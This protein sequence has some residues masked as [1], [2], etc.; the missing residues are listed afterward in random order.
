MTLGYHEDMWVTHGVSHYKEMRMSGRREEI[1]P[2]GLGDGKKQKEKKRYEERR[3]GRGRR[4][5]KIG[6]FFL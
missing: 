2:T 5:W 1:P 6:S 3:K 4:G